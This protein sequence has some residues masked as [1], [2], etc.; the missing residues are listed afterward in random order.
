MCA[1]V[2][3]QLELCSSL[4]YIYIRCDSDV[5]HM[6]LFILYEI[7]AVAAERRAASAVALMDLDK[8][9]ARLL[10]LS[11]GRVITPSP[12]A[13]WLIAPV[14]IPRSVLHT[15]RHSSNNIIKNPARL[16]IHVLI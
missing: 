4:F 10:E 13:A 6:Q 3:W 11:V 14:T 1:R 16:V 8:R 12:V 9:R 15:S 2:I 5:W 7:V